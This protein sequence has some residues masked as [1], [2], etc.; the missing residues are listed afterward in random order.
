MLVFVFSAKYVFVEV[1]TLL[2]VLLF[3]I[4]RNGLCVFMFMKQQEQVFFYINNLGD[5][6][7]LILEKKLTG[8]LVVD[9]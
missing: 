7:V 6:L 2:S 1:E 8:S 3:E 9:G 4:I 5:D